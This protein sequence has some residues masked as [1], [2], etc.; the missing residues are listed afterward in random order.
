MG[1]NG[2]AIRKLNNS[3]SDQEDKA[4]ETMGI[5]ANPYRAGGMI[6]SHDQFIGRVREI[7]DIL[8]RVATMQSV[9]IT[10]ERRI[11]KSSLLQHITAT[12]KKRLGDSYPEHVF[13]YLD[14]QPIE[15]AAEFYDRACKL[16]ECEEDLRAGEHATRDKD[17]ENVARDK[18][19][20]ENAIAGR[21]VVLCLDEFEQAVVADFGAEFFK[22]L[23][24]LAQTGNL[25]LIVAT[26]ISLSELYRRDE[27][28]T[29][30]FPNIFTQ[31]QLG[32]LTEDE[33]RQL[34]T[35]PRNGHRF[36]K[37][38]AD[39]IL[40]IAGNHPYRLNLAC[41]LFYDAEQD[42]LITEGRVPNDVREKLRADFEAK[43]AAS[44]DT[45]TASKTRSATGAIED[46]R[47]ILALSQARSSAGTER[48][49]LMRALWL[50]LI[51]L[52]IGV[53]ST[54]AGNP[55]GVIFAAAFLASG[56]FVMLSH[57]LKWRRGS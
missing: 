35:A 14:V 24:H 7:R 48:K 8:S 31:L 39:L 9:S 19:D 42:G 5:V 11:G 57:D 27:E 20:L 43:L 26:K 28:L 29:S 17:D 52:A 33:A 22:H 25:A 6:R 51:G 12:G 34:V 37:E 16:I 36:S 56:L 53:L 44:A 50:A 15:S 38:E 46:G 40:Q 45:H 49:V 2:P 13:Y 21:K 3:L 32:E 23:R 18:D 10:G 41:A 30:G 1:Y 47:S 54:R 4:M 55:V